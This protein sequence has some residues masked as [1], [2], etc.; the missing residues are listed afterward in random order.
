MQRSH[1]D[2]KF[3]STHQRRGLSF[4]IRHWERWN[5][6]Y[7]LTLLLCQVG[8]S[9][10]HPR[11]FNH[12]SK[13]PVSKLITEEM[14]FLRFYTR[15]DLLFNKFHCFNSCRTIIGWKPIRSFCWMSTFLLDYVSS[16][17]PQIGI[18]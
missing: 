1:R 11:A 10:W 14:L 17:H 4:I 8:P 7:V 2:A 16:K 15:L 12:Y 3:P 5:K 18:P 6:S 9:I 13:F